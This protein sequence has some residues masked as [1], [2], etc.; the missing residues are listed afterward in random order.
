MYKPN[1]ALIA[2]ALLAVVA[3]SPALAAP[4]SV[5]TPVEVRAKILKPLTMAYTGSL[6][7]GTILLNGLTAN[8]TIALS[9]ANVR[10][11]GAGTT[12][13]VCSGAT[14]VP[15][16]TVRGTNNEVVTIIKTASNLT[17]AATG[18]SLLMTL[19]GPTSVT[20]PNSGN[21]GASFAIGASITLTPTT[22]EGVY[23]GSVNVQVD[24]Q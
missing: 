24:Y 1:I 23:S 21:P 8:R 2:V 3:A 14:S 17:N 18:A 5:T 16:Y 11:C 4:A 10:D 12:Q 22:G 6:N 15:T 20:M 7:F 9:A 13:L 19:S